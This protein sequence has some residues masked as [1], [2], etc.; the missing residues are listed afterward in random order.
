MRSS[1][2]P[3]ELSALPIDSIVHCMSEAAPAA[4]AAWRSPSN[5]SSSASPRNLSTSP[6][7]R[8]ATSIRPSKQAEIRWTSSSAPALPFVASRSASAVK[9][10]MST[11]TSEPSSSRTRGASRLG[12]P[13]PDEARE[14]RREERVGAPHRAGFAL[15]HRLHPTHYAK[16]IGNFT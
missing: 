8:S 15:G 7:C 13:R 9:P 2:G 11:E 6:P 10:E 5:N 3:T 14:V 16:E 1:T 12:A 4:R